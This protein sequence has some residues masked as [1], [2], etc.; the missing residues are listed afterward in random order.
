LAAS[1][2][3]AD[4]VARETKRAVADVA[5]EVKIYPGIDIDV[6]VLGG[7]GKS[8]DKRTKPEDVSRALRA[9]FGAGADGVVLSREYVEMWLANLSAA[10]DTLREI[11]AQSKT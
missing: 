2:L 7:S 6:P 8:T 9:A 1:G 5:G 4:Y 10:G 3:S 11:F